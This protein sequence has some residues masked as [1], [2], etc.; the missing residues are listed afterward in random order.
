MIDNLTKYNAVSFLC[1]DSP[2]TFT[3][4]LKHPICKWKLRYTLSYGSVQRPRQ[5]RRLL[6]L[7][8][9]VQCP[10][11]SVCVCV[12]GWIRSSKMSWILVALLALSCT[13]S[14]QL[15]IET[16][17][18]AFLQKFD[19]EASEL[20]YQYSLASWAYNTNITKENSDKLVRIWRPLTIQIVQL[21]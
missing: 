5:H 12:C 18:R 6:K 13:V 17:A 15:D 8:K 21:L 10:P 3:V 1:E 4:P 2:V 19:E 16:K 11:S 9:R 7:Y 14:A 20:M